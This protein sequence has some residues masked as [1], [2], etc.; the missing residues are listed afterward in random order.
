MR[1]IDGMPVVDADKPVTIHI[2]PADCER[3]SKK[4]PMRCAAA[5]ALKRVTGCDET[6]VH[7]ACTYLR[8]RNKW[9]RYATPPSLKAEVISFD[10]RGGF[11][12]GDF[13]L[14]PMSPTLR[15]RP[16]ENSIP[17][18]GE[19][20]VAKRRAQTL[21]SDYKL[22]LRSQEANGEKETLRTQTPLKTPSSQRKMKAEPRI[23]HRVKGVREHARSSQ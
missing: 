21:C 18:L 13:R 19:K 16:K 8:F 14:R 4:D 15:L 17:Q 7:L 10:R 5:L 23:F 3:G 9:R 20:P 1:M 6:R 2:T 22:T 12:P 11:Y